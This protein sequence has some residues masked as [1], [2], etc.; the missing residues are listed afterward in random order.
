MMKFSPMES[1]TDSKS[2]DSL[3]K[4]LSI[5]GPILTP[6][7]SFHLAV[8]GLFTKGPCGKEE[9]VGTPIPT[10]SL[11]FSVRSYFFPS[12]KPAKNEPEGWISIS[13]TFSTGK[14]P[15]DFLAYLLQM[16]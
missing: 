15:L 7:Y 10:E 1:R 14:V 9:Q 2:L 8:Q 13:D 11:H 5:S 6:L 4:S 12:V 3:L 16:S